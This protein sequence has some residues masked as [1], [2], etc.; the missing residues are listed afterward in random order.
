MSWNNLKE[1]ESL[2]QKCAVRN[3]PFYISQSK[4][5]AVRIPELKSLT[6]ENVN[7]E[8]KESI[9]QSILNASDL[10]VKNSS[11]FFPGLIS[12]FLESLIGNDQ[13]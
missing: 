2:K 11:V 13:R 1:M 3:N 7:P 8:L 12:S 5:S 6:K 9:N 4:G 10:S